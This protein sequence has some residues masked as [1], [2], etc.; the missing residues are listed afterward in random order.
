[1]TPH[2]SALFAALAHAKGRAL[3]PQF[4]DG[5]LDV[6]WGTITERRSTSTVKVLVHRLRKQLGHDAIETVDGRYRLKLPG[7]GA[8]GVR[9]EPTHVEGG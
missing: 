6:R 1:M 2:E 4:L 3:T 5:Q 8:P 9:H 7:E